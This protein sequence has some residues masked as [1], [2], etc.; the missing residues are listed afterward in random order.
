[1]N[2]NRQK[3]ESGKIFTAFALMLLT[4]TV[5]FSDGFI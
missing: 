1:M 4:N 5:A 2:Y 3:K